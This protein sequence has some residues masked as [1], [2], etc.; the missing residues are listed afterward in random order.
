MSI[1]IW[2]TAPSK[3]YVG[4]TQASKVFV[5]DTQVRPVTPPSPIPSA[6][7]QVYYIQGVASGYSPIENPRIDTWIIPSINY[8]GLWLDRWWGEWWRSGW[9]NYAGSSRYSMGFY[10]WRY[11]YNYNTWI[12][13][14]TNTNHIQY[15][16]DYGT[17]RGQLKCVCEWNSNGGTMYL[18]DSNDDV[19]AQ[20]NYSW[21]IQTNGANLTYPLFVR[22]EAISSNNEWSSCQLYWCKIY[23]GS[24]SNLV[25]N[26]IPCYRKSDG[27]T[28]MYDTANGEFLAN[29]GTY[30]D[31]DTWKLREFILWP[32]VV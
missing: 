11:V 24:A 26:L 25:R 27:K 4:W 9:A 31:P 1:F 30:I 17:G 10:E 5:G 19:V 12:Y 28:W 16:W 18:Y 23:N 6:Y 29:Q 7:Q 22:K 21:N 2:D 13:N 32:N 14:G 15:L 8:F 20:E 3:I